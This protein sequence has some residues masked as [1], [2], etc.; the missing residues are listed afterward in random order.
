MFR[1]FL[2]RVDRQACCCDITE[3]IGYPS[4][5]GELYRTGDQDQYWQEGPKEKGSGCNFR[6][7]GNPESLKEVARFTCRHCGKR[8][9]TFQFT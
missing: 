7:H 2:Q 5:E 1:F 8:Y 4:N 3:F 9:F 6:A